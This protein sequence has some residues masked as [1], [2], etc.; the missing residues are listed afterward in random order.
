MPLASWPISP[1]GRYIVDVRLAGL[2]MQ[3]M[4]DLG[5]IDTR[6]EIGLELDPM[7]YDR[8]KQSGQFSDF[9]E[10]TRRD[11]SGATRRLP[12][13]R[14]LVNLVHPQTRQSI[15]PTCSLFAARGARGLPNRIGTEFFHR[16]TGCRVLW[17]LDARLWCV[18]YP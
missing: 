14:V 12:T 18:E 10:R 16:L 5:L 17:D 7:V 2:P 3:C 4:V 13:G 8:L 6:H 1:N 9:A 15:G 11:A